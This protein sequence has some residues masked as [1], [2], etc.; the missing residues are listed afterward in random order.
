MLIYEDGTVHY[1]GAMS[2]DRELRRPAIEAVCKATFEPAMLDGV[3][4]RSEF[5][6]ESY[7]YTYYKSH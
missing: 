5:V 3:P 4:V 7:F 1:A 2:G 6:I